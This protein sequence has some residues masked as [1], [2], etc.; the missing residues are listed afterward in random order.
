MGC[1]V[2]NIVLSS[3]GTLGV[4]EEAG[5]YSCKEGVWGRGSVQQKRSIQILPTPLR[6]PECLH[7]D[8]ISGV[9][10]NVLRSI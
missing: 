9:N 6:L 3:Y 4:V 7:N 5:G 1:I 10:N 2:V 8:T